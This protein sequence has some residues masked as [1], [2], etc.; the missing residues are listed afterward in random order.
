MKVDEL[1]IDGFKSYASRTVISGWDAQFNAITGLNGSG[2]S[3]ILD[4]I[5]FVLGIASM[6]TV[7]ASN[8]QDLIYKRGQAG[9][10]KASVTIVFDN[11]EVSKSPIGFETC[12][13][14]SVT[15][16]IILGGSSKYLINGHKAQQQTVLNLFQSVQLNINNPNFLIM[17]GKITKVLNM[18]PREILSLI[19][20]AAGTR[21]FE[22]RKDKAQKTMAKKEAKLVEIRS[23]LKEEIDPKLEKLRNEKRNYLEFQ[24]TQI[25]LEK[26]SR[27]VAAYDYTKLSQSF[28]NHANF[29]NQHES[30]MNDLRLE[31]DKLNNEI[32]NLND[33][34]NQV[35]AKKQAEL[36]NDSKLK[37]LEH[38][39]NQL[40]NEIARLNTTKDITIENLKEEQ[41]KKSRLETQL[42]DLD[43]NLKNSKDLYSNHEHAFNKSN[44][45]LNQLKEDLNKKEELL[46][47]LSTGMSS[48][49]SVSTGYSSQLNEAKENLNSSETFIKTS[50]LKIS[51]LNNQING[52][53]VKLDKAREENDD[54]LSN[55]KNY[56]AI[57]TDKQ[58]ELDKKLGFDPSRVS[59]LRNREASLA[60]QQ[61]KL[62]NELNYI[63]RQIDNLDFQYSRPSPNFDDNLVRGKVAR[64]FNL[65]E[66]SDDKATAL[67]VCAG[68]KL[69]NVIVDTSDVASQLLERGQ[70]KRRITFIPLDK[71]SSKSI[72]DGVVHYAK[73]IAPGKVELALNLI[74]F[75]NDLFKAMEYVFGTTFIC[76]DPN[77]SKTIT[78]DP[79]IR[80][81]SI[82]LEG[83]TYDP[84]GNISGGSRKNNSSVLVKL[85]QYNKIASKLKAVEIELSATRKEL[86]HID[87]LLSSTK[88]LQNEI[89]LKKHELSLLERKLASNPS[90]LIL[91]QNEANEAEINKLTQETEVHLEKCEQYKQEIARIEKDIKEFNSDKGSK[92]NDLKKETSELKIL[93][94]KKEQE[95]DELTERFQAIQVESEQQMAEVVNINESLASCDQIIEELTAKSLLEQEDSEKLA[96]KMSVIKSELEEV[97]SRLL[98]LDDEIKELTKLLKAKNDSVNQ[99]KL[100]MQKLTHELEKSKNLTTSLK[101][102]LDE[103]IN[104]HE[105]V[106]D[107]NI[108]E[109]LIQQYPGLNVEE[110]REQLNVLKE[111][112]ASMRRKVNVNIM[113][114]IDNVE[115]KE[116]SLKT[117]VKTIEKDKSKIEHTISKLNGY[118]RETLNTTYQKVS[119]DFGQ[120]FSDLLPGSFAKLV[121]VNM[122]DVTQGLEVKVKLGEVWKES[123]VE[124]SGGQRSLI[125]LSL[126]MA[127]LQ[128]KPAPMYILDEVDAALDLSH[129]Q[130]IGHLIKTRF[131]GSQF[132]VVSLKE[133]MFTNANRVF[134]TRFQDGTSVV[135]VM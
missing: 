77:T 36:Q 6:A 24:Q 11:S 78:F 39:E 7:R 97:R 130:N 74:D 45:E 35:K 65:S 101:S 71:I 67:Q 50:K 63:G 79:K 58:T 131:K 23:L 68:G 33:D 2:K 133:G 127:L 66:G 14:I 99:S 16:Q 108:L 121:P 28:T 81:R 1:I 90:S 8:L 15:R 20:E 83:D 55:I 5:C 132:I 116:A 54:L 13:T 118:K 117:M 56:Q 106:M 126:I 19:E 110:S 119:T 94:T 120:I 30:K 103:I 87:S 21:T 57:V 80:S 10:T 98:G 113:N 29:L 128:F 105:W 26:L 59:E 102:R 107:S 109:N 12:A 76:N 60:D 51:H 53:K 9:V 34:L 47:S 40:S 42:R 123:L 104:E 37:E 4:A 124:L 96:D 89:N 27:V 112:F 18:K 38:L 82:T 86:S 62:T 44:Q 85:Q 95:L 72:S 48:K 122:M 115:K 93:V 69:H 135:S 31:I 64:L 111:K 32:E 43:A 75:D 46:S 22:E 49:G 114:M 73:Q 92:I 100:E 52:D 129:T 134:R 61:N 41:K 3:N 84:E 91:K 70:L 25:D 17:Q 88:S 125:A